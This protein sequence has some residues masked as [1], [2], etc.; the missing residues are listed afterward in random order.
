MARRLSLEIPGIADQYAVTLLQEALGFIEDSNMWSFQLA[1]SGWLTPGLLFASGSQSVGTVTFTPYSNLVIGDTAASAAWAA[2]TGTLPL[3]TSFQIRSPAYSLYNIIK[4]DTTSHAPFGTLTLDRPW[5]EPGGAGQAYMIYQAYFPAPVA[6]FKRFLTAR[7]T[8]TSAPMN[9]WSMTQKELMIR[10]PQ[11]SVFS[12]PQYFVPYEIDMRQGSQ[13]P[14]N[15]LF[16]IWPHPLS[17]L[18]YSFAY[19]RKGPQLVNP[20]DTVP[21]QLSEELVLWRAKFAAYHY[22]EAQK[23]ENVER[24]SG[25]DYRF[26]SQAAHAEYLLALKPIR[27]KDD[28]LVNLYMSKIFRGCEFSGDY[29]FATTNQQ[30]N[31]GR[32]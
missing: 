10:D 4:Y 31:V 29:T 5:M 9:F 30:V 3:L 17:Q 7:D 24:G 2:Y 19:L 8:T 28:E 23:G 32:F 16:E 18:P 22:K 6:D 14:G 11:R 13:T 25:A 15:M 1:E 20:S 27:M 26:L 21:Y 12:L